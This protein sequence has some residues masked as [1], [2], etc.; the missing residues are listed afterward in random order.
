M[1]ESHQCDNI[2]QL[3]F[4]CIHSPP[5]IQLTRDLNH[6]PLRAKNMKVKI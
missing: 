2:E 3:A 1:R 4:Y 6:N 5:N